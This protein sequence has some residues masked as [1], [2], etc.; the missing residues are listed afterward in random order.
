MELIPEQN[1]PAMAVPD[2]PV[3]WLPYREVSF[4]LPTG[5]SPYVFRQTLT[6]VM[7]VL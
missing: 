3:L 4:E 7:E 2:V 6:V 5:F 1:Y